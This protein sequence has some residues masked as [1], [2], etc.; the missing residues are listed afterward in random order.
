[1][2]ARTHGRAAGEI[3]QALDVVVG[4]LAR[5]F[6]AAVGRRAIGLDALVEH[7]RDVLERG[8]RD[9]DRRAEHDF[10]G[11]NGGGIGGIGDREAIA[12]VGAA[13][14]KDR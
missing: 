12:A 13:H 2:S 4:L 11:A 8:H 10:G 14:R 5:A 1:L 6:G 3:A 7:G 9:L